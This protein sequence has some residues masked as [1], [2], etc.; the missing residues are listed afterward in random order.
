MSGDLTDSPSQPLILAMDTATDQAGV[1]IVGQGTISE[2]SW[3]AG[4]QQT[5][6][7]LPVIVEMLSDIGRTLADLDAVAVTIGPGS[8]TGLRVGLSIAKGIAIGHDCA[9]VGIPT[10][11]VTAA[12]LLESGC[13]CV[14]AASAGRGRVIWAAYDGESSATPTNATFAEFVAALSAYPGWLVAGEFGDEQRASMQAE[15]IHLA[16]PVAGVRR[17]GVL[18]HLARTRLLAGEVAD[19]VLLEPAYLH[20]RPNQR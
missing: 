4:R 20:G 1:A 2:R 15:G 19:P 3:P 8:F 18:A 9:L 14:A 13:R 10:L 11:D 5:V 16:S 6:A 17:P 7:L 12:P